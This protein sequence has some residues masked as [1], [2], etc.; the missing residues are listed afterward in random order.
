MS[1]LEKLREEVSHSRIKE[2][3]TILNTLWKNGIASDT[4]LESLHPISLFAFSQRFSSIHVPKEHEYLYRLLKIIPKKEQID[5]LHRFVEYLAW[6]LKFVTD[7][8]R[9]F[10]SDSEE[11]TLDYG[12]EYLTAMSAHKGIAA[13]F[14]ALQFAETSG[15]EELLRTMLR[16]GCN[17]IRQEI[18]HYFSC[19]DSVVRLAR[20]AGMPQAKNHIFVLTMYLMQSSPIVFEPYLKPTLKLDEIL[21]ELVKKGG[22]VGYH[23]MIVA[24]GLINNREFIGEKHYLHALHSL[25]TILPSLSDTLSK[26]NLDAIAKNTQKPTNPLKDLKE[27]IWKGDKAKA[28]A[29]LRQYLDEEGANDELKAAIAHT[30]TRINDF[31]HDPHYVTFPTSAFELIPHLKSDEVELILAHCVEFAVDR[32]QQHGIKP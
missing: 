13:L 9:T 32:V 16:I 8:T 27:H 23:F 2:S 29:T 28:F 7:E 19:T 5:F 4:I 11:R 15:L 31:P 30:Y 25:E 10:P 18:G 17:D 3:L 20:A 24:N 6:S 21:H 22:F 26:E 1:L 14:Y 12:K